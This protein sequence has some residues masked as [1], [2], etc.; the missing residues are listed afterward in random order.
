MGEVSTVW[1][2]ETHDSILW[3]DESRERSKVRR[4]LGHR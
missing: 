1:K 4:L 2:T 3:L